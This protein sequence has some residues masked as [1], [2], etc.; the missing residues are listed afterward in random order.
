M[1]THFSIFIIGI[2]IAMM[3]F[4]YKYELDKKQNWKNLLT[5]K[6]FEL[7]CTVLKKLLIRLILIR[8]K[9]LET[10]LNKEFDN[11]K[12]ISEIF[13]PKNQIFELSYFLL[14]FSEK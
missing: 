14:F 2:S 4:H 6:N 9:Y 5:L 3:F 10:N 7:K 1:T 11:F 12:D 13:P 8:K